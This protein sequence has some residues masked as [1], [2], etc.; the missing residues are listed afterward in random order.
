[1]LIVLGAYLLRINFLIRIPNEAPLLNM[2]Y[3]NMF[4]ISLFHTYNLT[5]ANWPLVICICR[6]KREWLDCWPEHMPKLSHLMHMSVIK[7]E[8]TCRLAVHRMQNG[9]PRHLLHRLYTKFLKSHL[10]N[11]P[12]VTCIQMKI[13]CSYFW[14]WIAGCCHV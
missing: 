9:S 7:E 14:P 2:F 6:G 11:W 5:D 8:E 13:I 10:E 3:I 1:M 12:A 4:Y